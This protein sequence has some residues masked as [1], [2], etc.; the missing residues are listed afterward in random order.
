MSL[1]LFL[2]H[3]ITTYIHHLLLYN[4]IPQNLVACNNLIYY[5]SFGELGYRDFLVESL[6]LGLLKSF[7]LSLAGTTVIATSTGNLLPSSFWWL[8]AGVSQLLADYWNGGPWCLLAI[9]WSPLSVSYHMCPYNMDLCI[10][11]F[12]NKEVNEER[13]PVKANSHFQK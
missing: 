3:Y 4:P 13:M 2:Q 1:V 8:L 9:G 12:G 11:N 5:F 6:F 10:I 7:K